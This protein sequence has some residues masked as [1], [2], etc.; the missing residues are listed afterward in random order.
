LQKREVLRKTFHI[1][2]ILLLLIPVELFGK[3]SIAILMAFMLL[4]IFPVAYFRIK[5]R[6]TAPFWKLLDFVE[7]DYNFKTLPGRQ[8]YSLALAILIVS[9]IFP[10]EIVKISI[11]TIAVYDGFSTIFGLLFGKHKVSIGKFKT[12]KSYEGF[13]GGVLMNTIALSLFIPLSKAI[14]ISFVAGIVELFSNDKKWYL[15]DN[16]TVTIFTAIFSYLLFKWY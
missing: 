2:S 13:F 11:I 14:V 9:L 1:I 5:N 16:L 4:T 12:K 10:E 8:A 7:R 3:Y 6:L 15:D